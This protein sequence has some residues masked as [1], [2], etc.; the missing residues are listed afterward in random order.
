MKP[1]MMKHISG[2][3]VGRFPVWMMR[4][5]GRYLPRYREIRKQ[6]GFWET[7][8][9]PDL[10]SQIS[11]L[12]MEVLPLDAVI[13]FSDILTLPF[14]IS[15]PVKMQESV[16]PVIEAPLIH[17]R[18]FDVFSQYDPRKHTPYVTEALQKIRA[19]ISED[20]ALLGFAGA[21][22]TVASYLIEGRATK[23]FAHIKRWMHDDPKSLKKALTL[24]ADATVI[25]LKSQ[26]EAGAHMVQLF[27]TWI[28]EMPKWFYT[29]YYSSILNRVFDGLNGANIPSIYFTKNSQHVL[30]EFPQLSVHGLSVDS[31]LS[32]PE[33]EKMTDRKFFLQGNL[34]PVLLLSGSEGLVRKKTR[35]LVQQAR[36]LKKPA[37]LN[38]GHGILP[39]TPFENAKA[40]VD[41]ARQM[42]I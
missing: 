36:E 30:S 32:L 29:E 27:D 13:F 12:P 3:P 34:D 33:V 11:L 26:V 5:A 24:L 35:F 39:G 16:G 6:Y 19:Q 18:D 14:S 21:P 31:L 4:Q 17:E 9:N 25:Y 7:V 1:L 10:A 2:E 22:W 28:G 41:E 38:L 42:W 23:Q 8:V 20:V 37:I 15:I 40:F